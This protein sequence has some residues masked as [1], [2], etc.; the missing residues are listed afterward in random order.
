MRAQKLVE[1]ESDPDGIAQ[2]SLHLVLRL[3]GV[4]EAEEAA[5]VQLVQD[6]TK[7]LVLASGRDW[8]S[9]L[10]FIKDG[11]TPASFTFI[12]IF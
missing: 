11:P 9:L 6:R 3:L 4:G 8:N 7:W 10:F 1:V 12:F 2:V 5:Q